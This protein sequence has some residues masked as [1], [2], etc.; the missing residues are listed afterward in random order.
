MTSPAYIQCAEKFNCPLI[1]LRLERLE[2]ASFRMTI[3]PPIER[4]HKS[5]DMLLLETHKMLEEWIRE[6]P[7]Q[8]LWLHRRW[9]SKKLTMNKTE[10]R[11]TPHE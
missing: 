3:Y 6:R 7:A 11:E 9:D 8:C 10:K 2:G 4:N 5:Q 1:P